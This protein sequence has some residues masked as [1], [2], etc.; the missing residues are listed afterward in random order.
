[1]KIL[2]NELVACNKKYSE[3]DENIEKW[4]QPQKKKSKENEIVI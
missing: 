1:M 2:A 3:H 4:F